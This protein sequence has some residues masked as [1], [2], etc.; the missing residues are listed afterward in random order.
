MVLAGPAGVK[1]FLFSGPWAFSPLGTS[2]DCDVP[3]GLNYVAQLGWGN[4]SGGGFTVSV[5]RTQ[6]AQRSTLPNLRL[7]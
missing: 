5:G 1:Y 2:W 3:R 4:L 6:P 7:S